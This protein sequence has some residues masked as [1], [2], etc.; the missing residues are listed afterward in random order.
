[1]IHHT[2]YYLDSQI[3]NKEIG[4]ACMGDRKG[5]YRDWGGNLK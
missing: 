1:M 4:V 2:E 3:K 5:A